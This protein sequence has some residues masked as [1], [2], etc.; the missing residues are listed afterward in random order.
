LIAS[1][2]SVAQNKN[3]WYFVCLFS[4]AICCYF[5][6]QVEQVGRKQSG[7]ALN[8]FVDISLD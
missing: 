1:S 4:F 3:T 2:L 5:S 8:Q 7:Y 6:L